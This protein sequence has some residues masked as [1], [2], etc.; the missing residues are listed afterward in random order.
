[1]RTKEVVIYTAIGVAVVYAYK[2]YQDS[3]NHQAKATLPPAVLMAKPRVVTATV[4]SK[5][6]PKVASARKPSS[7][8]GKKSLV[9]GGISAAAQFGCSHL[10]G[11]QKTLCQQGS[12][13][14]SQSWGY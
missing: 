6:V 9:S 13:I 14:L 4:R 1:M 7:N 12:G 11:V 3:K 2:K 10:S 8:S 5:P